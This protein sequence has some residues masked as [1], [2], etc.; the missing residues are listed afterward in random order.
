M[1]T[2]LVLSCLAA[3]LSPARAS[4][5]LDKSIDSWLGALER[6]DR[7]EA[8]RGAAFALGRMG[9]VGSMALADLAR[10]VQA[11]PDGAVRDM[12]AQAI[13][14]IVLTLNPPPASAWERC[15]PAL[16]KAAREDADAR[17]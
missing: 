7:P 15:G 8:R 14:E 6:G 13:G 12:A 17:V 4:S 1:R 3:G 10:R 2:L 5:F 9:P 16:L 11:D